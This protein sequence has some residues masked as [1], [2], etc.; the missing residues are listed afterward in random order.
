MPSPL[1]F[2]FSQ[3]HVPPK[4]LHPRQKLDN[5]NIVIYCDLQIHLLHGNNSLDLEMHINIQ[6]YIIL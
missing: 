6:V 5:E 3:T 1:A 2:I 4:K